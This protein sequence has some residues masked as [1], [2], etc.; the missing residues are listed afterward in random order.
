MLSPQLGHA[1]E[2]YAVTIEHNVVA[3]MR[4]GTALRAD[5][6]RPAAE[7]KFPVL[8]RRSPY[9]KS[10]PDATGFAFKAAARGYVVVNQDARF[11][12]AIALE[13]DKFHR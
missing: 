6:Y 5:I 3:T 8:L 2:A 9:D 10:N 7:G 4:D 11:A 13:G 1:A 12:G